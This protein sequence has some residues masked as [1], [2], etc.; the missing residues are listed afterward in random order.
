MILY[1][2]IDPSV[3][4]VR[5][6][7]PEQALAHITQCPFVCSI[8]KLHSLGTSIRLALFLFLFYFLYFLFLIL[9]N[10]KVNL[11]FCRLLMQT[12]WNYTINCARALIHTSHTKSR[13][14]NYWFGLWLVIKETT[15]LNDIM[16]TNYMNKSS[17][18]DRCS[19]SSLN[20]KQLRSYKLF[21]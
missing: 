16:L 3:C 2:F 4:L 17:R 12:Q 21:N 1:L 9:T 15:L 14:T 8:F 20:I 18:M 11:S 7:Q 6:A 13:L 10:K 19:F 5:M